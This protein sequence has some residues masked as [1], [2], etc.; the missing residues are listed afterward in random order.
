VGVDP[1]DGSPV[2][3]S[4]SDADG[5]GV[6]EHTLQEDFFTV[7]FELGPAYSRGR[8]VVTGTATVASKGVL[9]TSTELTCISDANVRQ[10]LG[11]APLQYTLQGADR[12]LV[13]PPLGKSPA[14]VLHRVAR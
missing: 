9:D 11:V 7:C 12:V 2:R 14:M 4:L 6:L 13:L 8:G 3:L 1:F 5:D 10:S